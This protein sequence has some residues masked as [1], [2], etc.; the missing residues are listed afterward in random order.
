MI[1][2]PPSAIDFLTLPGDLEFDACWNNR[3]IA[4]MGK[5]DLIAAKRIAG[6]PEDGIDVSN[7]TT[8]D[9]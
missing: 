9:E 8:P 1:G 6:R 5:E 2:V 4:D 3:I 7:L